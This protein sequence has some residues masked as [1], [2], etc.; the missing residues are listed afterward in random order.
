[1]RFSKDTTKFFIQNLFTENTVLKPANDTVAK[2]HGSKMRGHIA[3]YVPN[4]TEMN[5]YFQPLALAPNGGAL[6][7]AVTVRSQIQK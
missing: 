1:L 4:R 7:R 5:I 3:L 6:F 2:K